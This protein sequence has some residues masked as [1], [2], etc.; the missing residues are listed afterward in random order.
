MQGMANCHMQ[1]SCQTV[2][3]AP[4]ITAAPSVPLY[5]PAAIPSLA[6]VR[7]AHDYA[8]VPDAADLF[9]FTPSIFHVPLA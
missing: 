8:F 1:A 9:G 7:A 6:P 4:L 3:P 2:A 5:P